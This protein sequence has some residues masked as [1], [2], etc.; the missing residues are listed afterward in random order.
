MTSPA[1]R[2]LSLGAIALVSASS[3][4]IAPA[5]AQDTRPLTENTNL[6]RGCR[7]LNQAAQIFDNSA[8]GPTTNRIG[9]LAAGTQITLTGVVASGR[10]QFFL[11]SGTLSS[12]QPVGWL[13]A[14]NLGPCGS[15][16]PPTTRACFRANFG[17]VVRS[18]PATGT[19]IAGYNA[20]DNIF[21]STNPPTQSTT[22]DGRIWMAT[23]M[24]NGSTGWIARTGPN[25]VGSN[26]TP[27]PCP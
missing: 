22:S 24:F 6:I 8:L 15:T 17:L 25:G 20:G 4:A 9:T 3:V 21:A 5:L 19:V 1:L 12:V 27:Q 26:V 13:N 11:G 2:R 10:A 7:R 23:T 14:G 18:S 16:P